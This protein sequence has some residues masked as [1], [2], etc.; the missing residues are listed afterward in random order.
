MADAAV[1]SAAAAAVASAAAA[2]GSVGEVPAVTGSPRRLTRGQ[3]RRVVRAVRHAEQTT[4]VE[5]CVY[6]GAAGEDPRSHAEAL[7]A[8]SG[9]HTRPAI[10]LLVAPDAR[11]VEVVTSPEIRQRVSDRTC[12]DAIAAMIGYFARS[13]TTGGIVAGIRHLQTAAGPA[14]RQPSAAT[15]PDLIEEDEKEETTDASD[16]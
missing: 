7:F 9:L 8:T 13:D 12:A 6:L 14:I 11:R 2:A 5:F 1:A 16:R 4:G 3:R 10:L 15:F